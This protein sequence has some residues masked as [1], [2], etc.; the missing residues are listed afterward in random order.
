MCGTHVIGQHNPL[1]Q[2][3]VSQGQGGGGDL[4]IALQVTNGAT[5]AF[6]V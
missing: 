5:P 2:V 1:P 4:A 6:T 3:D